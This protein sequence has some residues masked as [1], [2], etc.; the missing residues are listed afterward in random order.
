MTSYPIEST[1]APPSQTAAA[2]SLPSSAQLRLGSVDGE[3][4]LGVS[5]CSGTCSSAATD[6]GTIPDADCVRWPFGSPCHECA[7]WKHVSPT[8]NLG[9][10]WV[11]G[12]TAGM[13]PQSRQRVVVFGHLPS[14]AHA[15]HTCCTHRKLYGVVVGSSR[16]CC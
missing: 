12:L 6:A 4:P 16:P 7:Q 3:R 1:A 10:I 15:R 9:E 14:S 11:A 5:C 8:R 2:L 13:L